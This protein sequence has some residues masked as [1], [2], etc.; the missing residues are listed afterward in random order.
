MNSL[1]LST[2]S[3]DKIN[4]KLVSGNIYKLAD[5]TKVTKKIAT[6]KKGSTVVAVRS[7]CATPKIGK[8]S[9]ADVA[10]LYMLALAD[11]Q[12]SGDTLVMERAV[13]DYHSSKLRLAIRN[14]ITGSLKPKSVPNMIRQFDAL[15]DSGAINQDQYERLVAALKN[16]PESDDSDDSDDSETEESETEE[17]ETV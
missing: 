17:S 2:L 14:S 4:N 15:L 7:R 10:G 1:D 16:E 9:D 13:I 3:A 8:L 5:G 11:L 6:T 12:A